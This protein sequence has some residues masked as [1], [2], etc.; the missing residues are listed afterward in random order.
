MTDDRGGARTLA[1]LALAEL[2]TAIIEG[3]LPPGSPVRLQEQVDRLSMSS[4]PI[5]EALRFLERS[6]LVDRTPHRGAQ[7]AEMSARDLNETYTI[8][9]ELETMAVRAA[10]EN[11]TEEDRDRL[12]QMMDRYAEASRRSDPAARGIHGDFHMA[13]Y[14]LSRSKWLLRLLPMLWDNS[15]RYRRLALPLR[16]TT[17]QRIVE[18]RA[19]VDACFAGDPD[20]A[21]QSLRDHLR[22]TFEVAIERLEKEEAEALATSEESPSG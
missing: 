10:A 4:V 1:D 21:E 18:H 20:A 5:R 22:N 16:G 11:M 15:E 2:R 6:G 17:E 19:I 8:R 13:L 14:R 7:V 9:L 3:E 12:L